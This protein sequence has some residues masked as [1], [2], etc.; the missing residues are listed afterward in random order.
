MVWGLFPTEPLSGENRYYIF[1]QGTYKVGRKGC[2]V[3]INKDKGVSRV[4]AEIVIDAMIAL[5]TQR[6]TS[7]I[8]AKVRIRDCS[9]YGTFISN[10]LV[11]KK[12]VH[13]FPSRETTLQEGDLV[14][15]GTGNATYRF[16]FVPFM[17]SV[18]C[19]V[20]FKKLQEKISLIGASAIRNW[21]MECTHVLVDDIAPFN[22]DI[23]DAIVGK[24]PL[25]CHKWV[26]VIAESNICTEIPCCSSH[27]PTLK[28][29]DLSVKFAD[30]MSRENCLRGYTFL[31]ESA[32]KY[33]LK[34]RL[35]A[36]LEV[37]GAKVIAVEAFYQSAQGSE[38]EGNERI[39][40]V[41]P[42]GSADGSESL[43][44]L[45]S[46]LRVNEMHLI[47]AT[48]S[49][50]LD[51]SVLV[52]P[53]VVIASSCSTDETV[54]ADS[55]EEVETA[56]SIP[57]SVALDTINIGESEGRREADV[58]I[59]MSDDQGDEGPI[60]RTNIESPHNESKMDVVTNRGDES[61]EKSEQVAC[62][63]DRYCGKMAREMKDEE[64]DAKN[65]DIIYSQDLV[66]R[67]LKLPAKA[68]SS[69]NNTV[70]NFK[71][72]RKMD[73]QSGNSFN[74]LIPFA[75]NPYKDSDYGNEEVAESIKEEKR[76]KQM[77]AV[78]DDLFNHEKGK[79][80]GTAGSLHGL[81]TRR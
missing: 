47:C 76:R 12:K 63:E 5:N 29:E 48:L 22:E 79:R 39:A 54:V 31:L 80:R 64:S 10:D 36:L 68:R 21:S 4:H 52:L 28:V 3:I 60:S 1:S 61:V 59:V 71:R 56:T 73:M 38:G 30:S 78:A 34:D 75:K 35:Q 67:D 23:V 45:S 8:D 77:E 42:A 13:E 37:S 46:L 16:S 6:N 41:I 33:Q 66:I 51:P 81:F 49:G 74:N 32:P 9:K 62:S 2:D 40:L 43:R 20:P 26:E 69:M 15:F 55:D 18:C 14:S 65:S 72:F 58:F 11:S 44:H 53:P 17:F 19:S 50:Q 27:A 25:V 7:R 57:N 24:K 70:V